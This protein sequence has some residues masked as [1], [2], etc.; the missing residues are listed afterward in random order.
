[1]KEKVSPNAEVA[2]EKELISESTN[3]RPVL[4]RVSLPVI[5]VAGKEK[6]IFLKSVSLVDC[7][8]I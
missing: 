3:V 6:L 8:S 7:S 5:H 2:E 4:E 1:M